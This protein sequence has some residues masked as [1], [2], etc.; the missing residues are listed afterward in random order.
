MPSRGSYLLRVGGTL[1]GDLTANGAII[2]EIRKFFEQRPKQ[3]AA[4]F[5]AKP[6]APWPDGFVLKDYHVCA[7]DLK[8]EEENKE[9]LISFRAEPHHILS[10]TLYANKDVMVPEVRWFYHSPEYKWH[11]DLKAKLRAWNQKIGPENLICWI[12]FRDW[13]WYCGNGGS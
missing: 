2:E 9:T 10:G 3:G 12:W 11:M 5:D 6:G 4:S 1:K 13:Q 7:W 8:V